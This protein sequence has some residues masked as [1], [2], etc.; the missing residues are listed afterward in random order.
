M[1]APDLV[2][3]LCWALLHV[4]LEQ[5]RMKRQCQQ[6]P[7]EIGEC[8]WRLQRTIGNAGQVPEGSVVVQDPEDSEGIPLVSV[9]MFFCFCFVLH[10]H[11]EAYLQAQLH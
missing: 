1:D 2:C 4:F 11:V 3:Q 8:S 6:E 5:T 10:G 7:L 9:Y